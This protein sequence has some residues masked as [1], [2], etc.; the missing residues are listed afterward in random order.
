MRKYREYAE[1]RT[2]RTKRVHG[3]N[4]IIALDVLGSLEEIVGFIEHDVA[5]QAA[6]DYLFELPFEFE[7]DDWK[8]MLHQLATRIGPVLG[9]RPS[10]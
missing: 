1:A 5:F 10:A 2:P 4:T 7:L 6:D 9:W 8:Q 3:K